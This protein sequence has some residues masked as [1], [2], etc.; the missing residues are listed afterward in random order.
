MVQIHSIDILY[1]NKTVKCLS[2]LINYKLNTVVL[3]G[4]FRIIFITHHLTP[5]ERQLLSSKKERS[6]CSPTAD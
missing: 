4:L 1:F 6:Q 2:Y 3:Y 5:Q